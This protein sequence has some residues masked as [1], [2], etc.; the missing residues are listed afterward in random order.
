MICTGCIES[1][2]NVPT[3]EAFEEVASII[4]A[5]GLDSEY[6]EDAEMAFRALT[7]VYDLVPAG[8][9]AELH[10]DFQRRLSELHTLSVNLDSF[11]EEAAL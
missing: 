8:L 3:N 2:K 6:R 9:S 7:L 1:D 10:A 11:D 5:W 4:T